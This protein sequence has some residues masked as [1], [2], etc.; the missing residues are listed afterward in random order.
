VLYELL[1]GRRLYDP[2]VLVAPG[3]A[4]RED[5]APDLGDER[6]DAPPALV[7]LLLEMLAKAPDHRPASAYEVYDR[8]RAIH[9]ARRRFDLGAYVATAFEPEITTLDAAISSALAALGRARP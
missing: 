6:E 2:A 1:A 3:R 7:E 8:L 5:P 4:I 9:G